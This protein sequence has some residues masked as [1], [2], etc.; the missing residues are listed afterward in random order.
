MLANS[1]T[2]IHSRLWCVFEA[3]QALQQKIPN[4]RMSG[5]AVHLLTGTKRTSLREHERA[6]EEKRKLEEARIKTELAARMG[7][8]E[9]LDDAGAEPM[10]F[11]EQLHAFREAAEVTA[12]VKLDVLCSKDSDLIDIK[13]GQC[14]KAA[15]EKRIR[16]ALHGCM[17]EVEK[18]IVSL[19]RDCI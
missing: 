19:I 15:D 10:N 17:A 2:P 18:L 4:V 16:A 9:L 6:A 14:S 1:T 7:N 12:L 13:T 8:P 3:H 5:D 11:G